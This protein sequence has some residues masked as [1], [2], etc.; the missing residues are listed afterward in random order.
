MGSEVSLVSCL[1]SPRPETLNK[2][3]ILIGS[4][5]GLGL[6][7][8]APG[9]FGALLGLGIHLAAA[10]WL[11]E[12]Y[13][14][15]GLIVGL[16][17]TIWANHVLT[18]WAQAEYSCSDPGNFVLD[19]VAGYLLVPMVYGDV[20]S[21]KAAC[22]GFFLFR[23]FDVIKLP[24]ARWIDRNWHNSWGIVLDDLVSAIYAGLCMQLIDRWAPFGMQVF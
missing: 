13:V 10:Y 22:I 1:Q 19:E 8:I 20:M 24:G 12:E 23:V 3:K 5:F 11:P 16:V 15:G 21:F 2:F 14:W 9:S 6:L 4:A 17:L 18:P 7:P